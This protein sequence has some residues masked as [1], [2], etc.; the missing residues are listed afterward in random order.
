MRDQLVFAEARR[1]LWRQLEDARQTSAVDIQQTLDGIDSHLASTSIRQRL[2][3]R[4]PSLELGDTL[5]CEWHA[6][7]LR[8]GRPASANASAPAPG[9]RPGTCAR[10]KGGTDR[11]CAP[12]A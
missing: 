5:R 10:R 4:Q 3:L 7:S 2:H 1:K 11:N 12:R 8:Q 9:H 6:V